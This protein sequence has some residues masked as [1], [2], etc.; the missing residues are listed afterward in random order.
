MLR[1]A[2]EEAVRVNSRTDS[3]YGNRQ[4]SRER[5]TVLS[6]DRARRMDRSDEHRNI[7][8]AHINSP[9]S[10]N[11][12]KRLQLHAWHAMVQA[13]S[14]CPLPGHACQ[15]SL[16]CSS[17]PPGTNTQVQ[18]LQ[19]T[20]ETIPCSYSGFMRVC[21]CMCVY[22]YIYASLL[23]QISTPQILPWTKIQHV[24]ILNTVIGCSKNRDWLDYTLLRS[25]RL[26]A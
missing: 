4:P 5:G 14:P 23:F 25:S 16:P 10:Q 18:I 17:W 7:P 3:K 2:F 11:G 6:S 8:R 22:I 20:A 1:R 24:Q 19:G 13:A 26:E 12:R 21:V 15:V 9:C